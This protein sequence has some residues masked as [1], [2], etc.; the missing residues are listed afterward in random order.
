MATC[1]A[2]AAGFEQPILHG[3]CTYGITC[4]A[5][6]MAYCDYQPERILSH[7]ARFSAPV[8]AGEVIAVDLWRDGDVISFEARMRDSGLKV[9][10]Y[11]KTVL[12]G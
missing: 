5:V 9:I 3:L 10:K 1:V 7:Q 11:G 12:R 2:A 4:R 6:M 8:L